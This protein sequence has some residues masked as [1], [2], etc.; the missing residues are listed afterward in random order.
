MKEVLNKKIK[1]FV[2]SRGYITKKYNESISILQ[3]R[4][5]KY[6]YFYY[7]TTS[8]KLFCFVHKEGEI[9][10]P[11]KDFDYKILWDK[12]RDIPVD[13]EGAIGECFE[14]FD[15][16]ADIE[17]IWHWFE[18]FFDISVGKEFFN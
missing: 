3:S 13:G 18:Y 12:L 1:S 2:E 15:I 14:H 16:G 8:N 5:N 11:L 9:T 17:D 4:M 10:L 6:D 7:I